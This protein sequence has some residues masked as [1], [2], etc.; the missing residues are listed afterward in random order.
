M[1]PRPDQAVRCR[2]DSGRHRALRLGAPGRIRSEAAFAMLAGV[3]PIPA[4]SGQTTKRYRLNRY[5]DRQLN[6]AICTVVLCRL[7]HDGLTPTSLAAMP[8]ARPPERLSAASSV[9][10]LEKR[11]GQAGNSP[12]A[13]VES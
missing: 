5:G 7:R 13:A 1:A 2:P 9:T 4:N 6:R 3:A 11:S 8:K 10:L 12:V